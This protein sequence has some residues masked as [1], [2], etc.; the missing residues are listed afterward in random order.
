MPRSSEWFLPYRNMYPHTSINC[1]FPVSGKPRKVH[2]DW[3][4]RLLRCQAT[5][6]DLMHKTMF[7]TWYILNTRR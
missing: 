7:D 3:C 6:R 1:P 5:I 2:I 4:K